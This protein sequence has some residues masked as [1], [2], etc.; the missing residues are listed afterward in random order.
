VTILTCD[1]YFFAQL[2]M[3]GSGK[4]GVHCR[5]EGHVLYHWGE[6]LYPGVLLYVTMN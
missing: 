6:G 5:V 3:T 2:T 1:M 4:Q